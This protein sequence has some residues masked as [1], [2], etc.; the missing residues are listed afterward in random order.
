[1][2]ARVANKIV[3]CFGF[4]QPWSC[5][6]T[7]SHD[8]EHAIVTDAPGT[9][10]PMNPLPP[11][12]ELEMDLRPW[13][14]AFRGSPASKT[15]SV[16]GIHSVPSVS[17]IPSLPRAIPLSPSLFRVASSCS[18]SSTSSSYSRL[19]ESLSSSPIE[20]R[21]STAEGMQPDASVAP[22]VHVAPSVISD[23]T[24]ASASVSA[25]HSE[26]FPTPVGLGHRTEKKPE[27][28]ASPKQEVYTSEDVQGENNAPCLKL[29]RIEVSL[30]TGS[31]TRSKSAACLRLSNSSDKTAASTP[32]PECRASLDLLKAASLDLSRSRTAS[33]RTGFLDREDKVAPVTEPKSEA[34]T[35]DV[36]QGESG[37]PCL[38]LRGL[39]ARSRPVSLVL[40]DRQPARIAPLA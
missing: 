36:V 34:F 31:V 19:S 27:T 35:S 21:D 40:G 25:L 8:K 32:K 2:Y 20:H 13:Y 11:K 15:S 3:Q 39:G 6:P 4:F 26:P 5:P 16:R 23:G 18:S 14:P 33:I 22:R 17:S 9:Q 30:R 1:M 7:A 12:P 29:R 37:A 10:P 28:L 38:K 24:I